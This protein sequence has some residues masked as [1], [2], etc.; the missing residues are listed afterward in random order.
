[1]DRAT[2]V[3]KAQAIIKDYQP[4]ARNPTKKLEEETKVLIAKR[5]KDK[6]PAKTIRAIQPS[7]SRTAELYG[8]PKSH[9]D[10]IPLRPIVSASGDPLDKLSWL[11]ERIITQLLVFVPAHLQNTYD[12][13]NRL[14]TKFPHGLP[15]GSI[16][17]SVDVTNLYG[18]VPISEAISFT[19]DLIKRHKDK[20]GLYGL[21]LSDI[22]VL[23]EHRLN[24][25]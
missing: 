11:L 13:L 8:L 14:H 3:E 12:Y 16:A 19:L 21:T 15:S 25:N 23:L 22:K 20:I 5:M 24:N 4:V 1:M 2:Y 6:V 10:N 18:N 7:C 9:K 17:F